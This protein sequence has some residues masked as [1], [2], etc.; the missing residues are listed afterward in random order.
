M[1]LRANNKGDGGFEITPEGI[2]HAVC[3]GVID[4]GTQKSQYNG[5]EKLQH[6]CVIIWEFKNLRTE[7]DKPMVISNMYTVSL[8]E[9]SNLYKH[10]KSW[11]GK[12]F[13]TEELE[14]FDLT[15]LQGK[16]CM[17]QVIHNKK[18]DKTYANI[19]NIMPIMEDVELIKSESSPIVYELQPGFIPEDMYEWIEK[20]IKASVEWNE[21]KS[22]APEEKS[23]TEPF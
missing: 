5:K 2:H 16:N 12:S 4:I 6:K 7:D 21:E 15:A 18:D 20:K 22:Q 1:G 23:D 11:R 9:R 19:E 3:Y 8:D 10:L 13:T 14:D 17:L